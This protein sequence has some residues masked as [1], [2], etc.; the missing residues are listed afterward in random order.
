VASD[1]E[2]V[3]RFVR[4]GQA[5]RQLN[6]PN[7]VRM[8]DAVE[9]D[10]RHYLIIEYVPG[11]SLRDL[12]DR[13]C[14][15]GIPMPGLPVARAVEIALDVA[16][17]LTR[18]HRLGIV[19][20][21]L[22]PANVLLAEDGTPRLSDFGLAQ[23]SARS[24]LTQTGTVVGTILYISP[25]ACRGEALD[26]RAD[27]WAFGAML[28]EMLTGAHPFA[29]DTLAAVV[30][31]I[32]TQPVPDL[33]Q[34]RPDVPDPL[35]DLVYRML[36][37]DRQ[38]RIPSVRLVDAE[39]EAILA[40]GGKRDAG[41]KR[42]EAGPGYPPSTASRFATP[43]PPAE[44]R[45]NLPVQT[46]PFVG[47]EAELD[48]LDG[49]LADPDVR[50]VTV[51]GVGG[52]GKT[53]LALEAAAR[54]VDRYAHGVY[55]CSLAALRLAETIVLSIAKALGFAL[56]QGLDPKQQLLNYL[57]Q[58]KVLLL[59]DNYEHL[60][61]GVGLVSEMLRAAPEIVILATSR[62]RLGIQDEHLYHLSGMDYPDWET[63]EDALAYSA[64][65]LFLQSARRVR[66]GFELVA[67]DLKY[68]SRIC[69]LVGGM[70]L[71]ILLAAAWVEMLTLEEIATEIA[72]SLDILE[73]DLRDVPARQRSTGC[74]R[75]AAQ[76]A[77]RLQLLVGLADR[78]GT[79]G[80]PGTLCLSGRLCARGS[81]GGDRR[82]VAQIDEPGQQ[83]AVASR[84]HR[85]IRGARA[86]APIR[87]GKARPVAGRRERRAR[88]AQRLLRRSA[89]EV[90]SGL[91]ERSAAN[92]PGRDGRRD[93]QRTSG[94][95]AGGGAQTYGATGSCTG[96]VVPVLSD[97]GAPSRGRICLPGGGRRIGGCDV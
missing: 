71:G 41:G 9:Q 28:Y 45:H 67:G 40:G 65:K 3:P 12:L 78:A 66:P 89:A 64:V 31:A 24:R 76:H 8:V 53:R 36:E 88:P 5:L 60:L 97:T 7:I 55:F 90:G 2:V 51:L 25:E 52:M 42:Q 58:K 14:G 69:R 17:A 93:R 18:A 37:K 43:T 73:T 96:G 62:V 19:H 74:A 35:A 46:T 10:G 87:G 4:E 57:R 26:A 59:L 6:H 77:R 34:V 91:E 23:V 32:L 68:V 70:P 16:D 29:G 94:L 63:P 11:G 50:L 15:P 86:A 72:R 30:T 80:I 56:Y 92:G 44:A 49:L 22:K 95:G 81:P 61:D 27:I 83:V 20:R 39:L 75:A 79:R 84:A 82:L 21:D 13:Q 85:A 1:P 47:R 38:Q 54:Q 33:S 48:E